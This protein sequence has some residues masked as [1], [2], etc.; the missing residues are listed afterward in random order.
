VSCTTLASTLDNDSSRSSDA[1]GANGGARDAG[2]SAGNGGGSSSGSGSSPRQTDAA[3]TAAASSKWCSDLSCSGS[4]GAAGSGA[5]AADAAA[6]PVSLG[7][8]RGGAP[9]GLESKQRGGSSALAALTAIDCITEESSSAATSRAGS[10]DSSAHN[11]CELWRDTSADKDMQQQQQGSPR[12]ALPQL[13]SARLTAARSLPAVLSWSGLLQR[14]GSGACDAALSAHTAPAGCDVDSSSDT[15]GSSRGASRSS[16]SGAL[17]ARGAAPLQDAGGCAEH[18]QQAG[19]LASAAAGHEPAAAAAAA[20]TA[21]HTPAPAPAPSAAGA[22]KDTAPGGPAA[23]VKEKRVRFAM[24]RP[25]GCTAS[26][27]FSLLYAAPE[28]VRGER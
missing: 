26:R 25:A 8:N 11:G 14:T 7:C 20:C 16:G 12:S 9:T 6:E 27:D 21:Q 10:R 23:A 22:R 5:H 19:T 18:Q 2:G 24:E 4:G 28:L 1:R 17:A 15:S 13:L 3:L